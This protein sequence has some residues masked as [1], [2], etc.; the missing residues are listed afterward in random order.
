M[1][2]IEQQITSPAVG[3]DHSGSAADFSEEWSRIWE[4]GSY[5]QD[6]S[7]TSTSACGREN[8]S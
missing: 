7:T 2:T 8:L 4:D 5:Q 3:T 1:N 6:V